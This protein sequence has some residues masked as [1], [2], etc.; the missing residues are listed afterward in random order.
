MTGSTSPRLL[1]AHRIELMQRLGHLDP[2]YILADPDV[3]RAAVAGSSTPERSSISV[4]FGP[5]PPARLP[6]AYPESDMSSLR[7]APA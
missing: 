2:A 4:L 5:V 7:Q 6:L 3:V 1:G